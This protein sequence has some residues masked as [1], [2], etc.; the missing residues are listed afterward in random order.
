MKL[1]KLVLPVACWVL[2]VLS[3]A[4]A[5]ESR[6][7]TA[8]SITFGDRGE[9][10]VDGKRHF[11]RGGYRSGDGDTVAEGLSS[12]AGAGFDMIHDYRFESI[13]VAGGAQEYIEAARNYLRKADELKLGVFL[14]LPRQA[15]KQADEK[16]ITQIVNE[17]SSEHAL[18]MW[19]LADEP[20]PSKVSVDAIA[21]VYALMRRLDPKHPA[22]ITANKPNSAQ[23]Y[24]PYCDILWFDHYPISA[25]HEKQD[26]L[27][28]QSDELKMV[29]STASPGKPVWPVLQ[30]FDN[31]GSPKLRAK[32]HKPM[33]RPNDSNHRPNEAE[34][35]AQAHIAIANRAMAVLYYWAPDD[36]YSMRKDTPGVW[37]SLSRVLHELGDLEPVL[38]SPEAPGTI[39]MKGG[40]DDV[41]MWT[42]ASGG[43]VY[44]GVANSN[45]HSPAN[46]KVEGAGGGGVKQILGDG[47]VQAADNHYDVRLGPAGV[48]VFTTGAR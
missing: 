8:A 25:T 14:G 17:L 24:Q 16:V 15:V 18:W 29:Q 31:R 41:M 35:R 3:S 2:S 13:N 22:I 45:I 38:L 20:N 21:R 32:L 10:I 1:A 28:S 4:T 11:I 36:W 46:V 6:P 40:G 27:R 37:R 47:S 19:Y 9:L 12:A 44:V 42:R 34:L 39:A 30:A 7:S 33:D 26:S 23:Q 43:L 5:A 48:I